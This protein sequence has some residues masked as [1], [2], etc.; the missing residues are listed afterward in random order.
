MENLLIKYIVGE[1]DDVE[2][3]Q[4]EVWMAA[5]PENKKTFERI[6]TIWDNSNNPQANEPDVALAWQKFLENRAAANAA[7]STPM[8]IRKGG[9]W[10]LMSAAAAILIVALTGFLFYWNSPVQYESFAQSKAFTLSDKSIVTLNS[11]SKLTYARSFNRKERVVNLE[12]EAFFDVSKNPK[13]P[14][15]INVNNVAVKVLGTSFN[16]RSTSD[17]TE[18]VVETGLVKVTRGAAEYTLSPHQ[19]LTF[20][21][22]EAKPEI[23]TISN[24]LYQYYRTKIFVCDR[25]SLQDLVNTLSDAYNVEITIAN[26]IL[27]Q[28]QL[29]GKYPQTDAVKDILEV[30][31]ATLNARI[32]QQGKVYVIK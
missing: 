6:K 24:Q 32:E 19:K 28:Q 15:V 10:K 27:E 1:A 25:T 14:F 26:P 20:K 16:I 4:I 7:S 22:N 13:K 9:K 8:N 21:S 18:I 30:V 2:R 23:S 29:N 12:G 17:V 5:T 11:V 31:A 3:K